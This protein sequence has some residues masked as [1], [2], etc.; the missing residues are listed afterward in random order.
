MSHL[1]NF[2][3]FLFFTVPLN[4]NDD[5]RYGVS[6][7]A[8]GNGGD[9]FPKNRDLCVCHGFAKQCYRRGIDT[10]TSTRGH[11]YRARV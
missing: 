5:V 6:V 3:L 1:V 8:L 4:V 7:D 11:I 10:G 9:A 2:L